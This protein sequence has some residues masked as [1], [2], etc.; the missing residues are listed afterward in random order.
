MRLSHCPLLP[1]AR[2]ASGPTG[3]PPDEF[4]SR[5]PCDTGVEVAG[6]WLLVEACE[7][8]LAERTNQLSKMMDDLEMKD[9]QLALKDQQLELHHRI[10]NL[11]V[12]L[13]SVHEYRQKKA[14]GIYSS[15]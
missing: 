6:L 7:R 3:L 12:H 15:I 14:V 2:E 1:S 4:S 9:H 13:V 11:E 5:V 8:T 10:V